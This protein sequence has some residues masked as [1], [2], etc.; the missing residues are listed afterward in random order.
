[1]RRV[2][3][4]GLFLLLAGATS[5]GQI[6]YTISGPVVGDIGQAHLVG[7]TFT[8]HIYIDS[9]ALPNELGRF[10]GSYE[11]DGLPRAALY[12]NYDWDV[13]I[14]NRPDGAADFFQQ[15]HNSLRYYAIEATLDRLT[16]HTLFLFGPVADGGQLMRMKA[17][18]Y[19][20]GTGERLNVVRYGLAGAPYGY[21]GL[22]VFAPS[23]IHYARN[24][25]LLGNEIGMSPANAIEPATY[26]AEL[27]AVPI[28]AAVWLFGGAL[29]VLGIMKRRESQSEV[30]G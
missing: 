29:G 9:E 10:D 4:A 26:S 5:A 7:S 28:P 16:F 23:D 19:V 27:A 12:W 1:M 14:T 30:R 20:E 3:V 25:L 18:G 24:S 22:P 8:M 2:I 6:T 15:G 17:A 11:S 21:S 13:A